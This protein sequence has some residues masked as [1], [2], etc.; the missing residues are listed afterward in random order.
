MGNF[1]YFRWYDSDGR[2]LELQSDSVGS[3]T[4]MAG[5]YIE[6]IH[7]ITIRQQ[8]PFT[9]SHPVNLHFSSSLRSLSMILDASVSSTTTCYRLHDC[10]S[11]EL[12]NQHCDCVNVSLVSLHFIIGE[13]LLTWGDMSMNLAMWNINGEEN[14]LIGFVN[15]IDAPTNTLAER[16]HGCANERTRKQGRAVGRNASRGHESLLHKRTH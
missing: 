5:L 2:Y 9:L 11:R 12:V 1:D 10:L 15:N 6:L 13:E 16:R 8:T 14:D 4:T 7:I 3:S